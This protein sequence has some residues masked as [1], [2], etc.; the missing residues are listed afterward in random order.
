MT[1]TPP[2][3]SLLE[4]TG[5]K[6]HFGQ[7][8]SFL[9]RVLGGSGTVHAV[10]GVDLSVDAGETVAVVGESGCGKTTL[11]HTILR[12]EEPTAGSVTYDGTDLTGLS[13]S[14]MRS[15][16]RE[17]QMI[18]QD[19]QASL[20]PRKTV[21][22]VLE[23]PLR[24][25]D[26]G[27]DTE[28][29]RERVK[30]ML[31]R[32]GLKRNHVNRHPRQFSGGQQQ[33]LG[34]ARALMV[35]PR[36][37]VADEPTSALDVSVQAQILNLLNELQAEMD[38]AVLFITHDLSVV[39]HTADRVAV[40]YLGEVV[41]SG[42]TERIFEDARHPYTRSLL[43]SVPRIDPDARTERQLLD[44]S[45]PSPID[46]P[47]GCR[48]HTR[49]PDIVPPADWQGS[50]PLFRTAFDFRRRID[51]DDID[52]SAVETRLE[53]RGEET[54]AAAVADH[55]LARTFGDEFDALSADRQNA[56]REAATALARRNDTDARERVAAALPS[57][58]VS[59]TPSNYAATPN[60][61]AACLRESDDYDTRPSAGEPTETPR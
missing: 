38:L 44:G 58:C 6:K 16:R 12:L 20:N 43:S 37:I 31:E 42:P 45:V 51:A 55:L 14:E 52:V 49:C 61:E 19:P 34:I 1:T 56:L 21:G 29:R 15:F 28:D 27:L 40:M 46:P 59:T 53:A 26:I 32:V 10:D 50:Q 9:D 36:L 11:G 41:E 18:F 54:T 60:H 25:H 17:M 35:E 13:N 3:E 5:L 24:V 22:E 30:E 23:A 57:P 8:D 33:R 7:S 48:F 4:V 47:S 2:T 39:R